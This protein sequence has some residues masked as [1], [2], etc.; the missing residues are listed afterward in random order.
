MDNKDSELIDKIRQQ[1]DFGS[2]PR[3]EV[4]RSPKNDTSALY[5][6]NL[7]TPY[8]L[9]DQKFIS[10]EGK[11]ILDAGCGTGY[12]SLVLAEANPGAQIV[13]IDLSEESVKLARQRLEYHGF[14]N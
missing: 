6:H 3:I 5:F 10:T 14:G 1:F 4:D 13:G 12:K 2:Y 8:Y 11:V 9:R 7:V